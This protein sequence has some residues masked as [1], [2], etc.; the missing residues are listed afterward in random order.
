MARGLLKKNNL[1]FFW[2]MKV[3]EVAE[4]PE[5]MAL[6]DKA[7]LIMTSPINKVSSMNC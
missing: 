4:K 3:Q 6:K 2:F 5:R 7:S 1:D